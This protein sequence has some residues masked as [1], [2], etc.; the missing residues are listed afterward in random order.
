MNV[1]V[2]GFTAHDL[3]MLKRAMAE[4]A[5]D[6]TKDFIEYV[7]RLEKTLHVVGAD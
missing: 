2:L 4:R 3:F 1:I 7:Q 6:T 5:K